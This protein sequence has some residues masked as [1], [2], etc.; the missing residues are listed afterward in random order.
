[1]GPFK[2]RATCAGPFR[3][4]LSVEDSCF[5]C[6]K[7]SSGSSSSSGSGSWGGTGGCSSSSRGSG[8]PLYGSS[9]GG[10]SGGSGS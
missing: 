10:G 8:I 7:T 4:G 9:I 3:P 2:G 6:L 5:V 1:M